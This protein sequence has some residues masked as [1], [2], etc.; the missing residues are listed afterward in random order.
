MTASTYSPTKCQQTS[1]MNHEPQEHVLETGFAAGR[2]GIQP[3][4]QPY[5]PRH[6]LDQHVAGIKIVECLTPEST[7]A[8]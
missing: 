8:K 3:V 5:S 1:E 2:Q 4:A 7:R 6:T